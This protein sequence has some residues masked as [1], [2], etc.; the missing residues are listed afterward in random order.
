[1]EAY[2]SN[3]SFIDSV[4]EDKNPTDSYAIIP[5]YIFST[6]DAEYYVVHLSVHPRATASLLTGTIEGHLFGEGQGDS[7]YFYVGE[8]I[9]KHSTT[10]PASKPP[11]REDRLNAYLEA[12]WIE[13]VIQ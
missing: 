6:S 8:P 12:L 13:E 5:S 7:L 4:Y 2:D 3:G 11:T 9:K 1:M 10:T